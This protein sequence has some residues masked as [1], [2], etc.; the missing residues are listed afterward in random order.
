MNTRTIPT[1]TIARADMLI[2]ASLLLEGRAIPVHQDAA[3]ANRL[4]RIRRAA[5]K[6]NNARHPGQ[7]ALRCVAKVLELTA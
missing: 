1:D 5:L 3:N 6:V 7:A 4:Q 2:T